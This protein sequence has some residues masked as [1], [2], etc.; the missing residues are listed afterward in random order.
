MEF[1]EARRRVGELRQTIE[2][3][4]RLYFQESN[5][6]IPD[7]EYDGLKAELVR[8]E[9][10]FPELDQGDSPTRRV[11]DD[12]LPGFATYRHRV[13]MQSLDNTYSEE[14]LH[15]FHQRLIRA[16]GDENPIYVVEP[17]I[18]GVAVSLTFE[19][20]RFIRA[21]TRG[22]GVQGDDVT[23][24]VRGIRSLPKALSGATPP[25]MIE[26]RGEIYMTTEEFQRING[27]REE[28]GQ[29]V[30]A[31]PR[32]LTSGT[33]KL[34]DRREV[35]QRH[36]EIV[37]YGLGHSEGLKLE[38]QEGYHEILR[39]WNLPTV[40][41][42]WTVEGIDE[43]WAAIQELDA[44]REGF[45]YAT[46]GAVIKLNSLALQQEVGATAKSPRWA[47]AY[48]FA[49]ERAETVLRAISIQVG[50]T[51][52]LTPV[53]ELEPVHLAG[54]TVSRATLHNAGEIA[55]KDVRVGD[56]VLVEK[57][58]EII[59]AVIEVNLAKRP[60][61]SKPFEFPANCPI[62]AT[63]TVQL[64]GEVARRC[65]NLDCPAQVRRRVGHFASKQSLDIDGLGE[66]VVDQLVSR[67]LV[68]RLSDLYRLKREDL[69]ELEK[70]GEKSADN[71]LR[72][73][74]ISKTAELWRVIH[75]LGIQQVGATTARDL[76]RVFGSLDELADATPEGLVAVEGIG[77]K[78]AEGIR[79]YFDLEAN[80]AL[81]DEL[82][83]LGLKPE[84]PKGDEAGG[85][86]FEG[87]TFVLTGTLPSLTRDEARVKIE[88]AGGR[89]TSSVSRKTDFVL[90]GSDA[91]SKLTKARKLGV[92]VVDE[93]RLME[94]LA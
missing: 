23:E 43:A 63:P 41:K 16:S 4:D 75:G 42:I 65:P 67:D 14:E 85:S 80:R 47:I 20:G 44:M 39:E 84:S 31:N 34:L 90:A 53:A 38:T 2:Q 5:P 60:S 15:A 6:E 21:V 72:A 82:M 46:D 18:D 86:L 50:R 88:A 7:R 11:G 68:K 28:A 94:M 73:I 27:L 54:T 35:A 66:A 61:D 77:E 9:A 19:E 25:A 52:V 26:I 10:A 71:L 92:E 32:N 58:G 13:P 40:E 24:N 17:K 33:I 3:H 36:L 57:A 59:P 64:E 69:L 76:A 55:R 12:R 91:G 89:V 48:K 1:E 79:A 51:G 74:E 87:K 81:I 37:L 49:A 29:A 30:Y 70:F 83:A 62:C 93:D 56:A 8:L 45:A 22:N 78:S